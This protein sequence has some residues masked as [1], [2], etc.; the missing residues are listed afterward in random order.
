M[1]RWMNSPQKKDQEITARH[2][3]KTD[4]S[5]VYE[6]ECKPTVLRIVAGLEKNIDDTREAL[7]ADIKD[8]KSSRPK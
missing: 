3:L 6:Q 7:A 4:I 2:F 8:L 1:T 5:N